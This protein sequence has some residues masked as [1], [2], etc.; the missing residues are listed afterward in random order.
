MNTNSKPVCPLHGPGNNMNLC[1]VAEETLQLYE[2][3]LVKR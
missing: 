2:I 3:N 1:E